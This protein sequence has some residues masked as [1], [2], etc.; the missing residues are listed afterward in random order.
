AD[1]TPNH[2]ELARR[3]VTFDNFHA[4]AEVSA[5]GWSWTTGAYANTY[6]QKNWPLDYNGYGRSTWDFGGFGNDERAALPGGEPGTGYLWDA[7]GHSGVD[8]TNFG[9]YMDNPID[10]V[11][12]MP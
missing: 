2:H 7:L 1:V 9:L 12:S 8:Y 3:F 11:D 5:D 4:D 10:L 6:N